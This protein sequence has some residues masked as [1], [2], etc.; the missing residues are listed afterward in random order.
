[1][2]GG[3]EAPDFVVFRGRPKN[4]GELSLSDQHY[5]SLRGGNGAKVMTSEGYT[6]SV[7]ARRCAD[8]IAARF[9]R[10]VRWTPG[11]VAGSWHGWVLELPRPA[12]ANPVFPRRID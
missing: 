5:L 6:R 4:R 10:K 8:R 3:P 1:M 11:D 12:I 2:N 9:G 7:S